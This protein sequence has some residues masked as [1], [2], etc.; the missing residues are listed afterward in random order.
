MLSTTFEPDDATAAI[1]ALGIDLVRATGRLTRCPPPESPGDRRTA[2]ARPGRFLHAARDRPS[3]GRRAPAESPRGWRA[4]RWRRPA[5]RSA[6]P[7]PAAIE[8][9]LEDRERRAVLLQQAAQR[10]PPAL[11]LRLR[12]RRRQRQ[13]DRHAALR[14]R[15]E[16]RVERRHRPGTPRRSPEPRKESRSR[17]AASSA[18]SAAP[19]GSSSI[20][21][22]GSRRRR[23]RG[24]ACAAGQA[25][26]QA[27]AQKTTA[28]TKLVFTGLPILVPCLRC[29]RTARPRRL[30][31]ADRRNR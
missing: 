5:S 10:D 13:P 14:E 25:A 18:R 16:A 1:A 22:R 11:D 7:G 17:P 3:P 26:R 8:R 19:A 24:G 6:R 9:H 20:T 12:V 21:S 4:P 2:R 30:D 27:N 29:G 28:R 31:E 15:R 23:L